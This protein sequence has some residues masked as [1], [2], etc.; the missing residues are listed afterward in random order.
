MTSRVPTSSSVISMTKADG[1]VQPVVVSLESVDAGCR[2]AISLRDESDTSKW[3]RPA[4]AGNECVK[5]FFS[6][7]LLGYTSK[8]IDLTLTSEALPSPKMPTTKH[9]SFTKKSLKATAM[10]DLFGSMITHPCPTC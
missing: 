5:P 2:S 10:D 6:P 8:R 9:C 3:Y 1:K 7:T 4:E